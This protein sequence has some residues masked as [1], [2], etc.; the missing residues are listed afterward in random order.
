MQLNSM[1][2]TYKTNK[3][4]IPHPGLAEV[5][6]YIILQADT[7]VNYC[8]DRFGTSNTVADIWQIGK[9]RL[10]YEND[11]PQIE[12]IQSVQTLFENNIHNIPGA[13]E[14]DCFTVFTI[15]MLKASKHNIKK[16]SIYLQGNNNKTPS[17]VLTDYNGI[18][19]DFT[20]PTIDSIR[21]YNFYDIIKI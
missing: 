9:S 11:D 4:L 7:S 3:L 21:K 6:G 1:N 13:G 2:K 17:H 18:K 10:I 14:C 16:I 12:Q 5:L 20:Q 19:I 8:A 15:A